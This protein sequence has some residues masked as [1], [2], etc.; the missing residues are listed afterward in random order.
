MRSF[1][2][3]VMTA[4]QESALF[5]LVAKIEGIRGDMRGYQP[6]FTR[7]PAGFHS[8]IRGLI[9]YL[10]E[11]QPAGIWDL[12]KRNAE[13]LRSLKLRDYGDRLR[14]LRAFLQE[15][16]VALR[17][18][19]ADPSPTI[20]DAE[21]LDKVGGI[22]AHGDT[23]TFS[24]LRLA[25]AGFYRVRHIAASVQRL[26]RKIRVRGKSLTLDPTPNIAAVQGQMQ[27]KVTWFKIK[28]HFPDVHHPLFHSTAP[29]LAKRMLAGGAVLPRPEGE[30]PPK[31]EE[32]H[33]QRG[34]DSISFTRSLSVALHY[35]G[36]YTF[37][38]DR[39]TLKERGRGRL[40]PYA[41]WPEMGTEHPRYE[42]EDRW[43]GSSIPM[44]WFSGV[45]LDISR[46]DQEHAEEQ[47]VENPELFKGLTVI[48]PDLEVIPT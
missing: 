41:F 43:V 48:G 11:A 27:R 23:V 26:G 33:P 44:S 12:L 6:G 15:L 17:E 5:D 25:L 38:I 9:H 31:V 39:D 10:R 30:G 37:V 13:F 47:V 42:A 34:M 20:I 32:D 7:W 29:H 22:A 19:R 16:R 4:D 8:L 18:I 14:D 46:D 35:F 40:V 24:E 21:V 3:A 45:L 28:H 36:A 1:T 2:E